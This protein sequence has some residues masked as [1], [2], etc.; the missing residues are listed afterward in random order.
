MA[1]KGEFDN[2]SHVTITHSL[3]HTYVLKFRKK[4]SFTR[5]GTLFFCKL[6]TQDDLIYQIMI[7]YYFL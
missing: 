6:D 5:E 7:L 1:L 2:L 4:K 3:S